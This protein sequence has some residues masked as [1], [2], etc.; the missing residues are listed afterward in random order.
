MSMKRWKV[1]LGFDFGRNFGISRVMKFECSW[2]YTGGSQIEAKVFLEL[3]RSL[4]IFKHLKNQ[5]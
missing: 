1:H 2:K 3:L 4:N 5:N